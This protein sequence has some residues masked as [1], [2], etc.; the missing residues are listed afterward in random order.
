MPQSPIETTDRP[1]HDDPDG[2]WAQ[3][4]ILLGREVT[5]EPADPPRSGR[6]VVF[7]PRA[8]SLAPHPPGGRRVDQVDVVDVVDVVAPAGRGIRRHRVPA[9]YLSVAET[10]PLL[11]ELDSDHPLTPPPPGGGAGGAAGAA[12]WRRVWACWPAGGSFRQSPIR[13]MTGGEPGH[14]GRMTTV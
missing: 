7:D 9:T 3:P 12:G 10:L 5:F 6:F 13:D 8:K 1:D 4:G 11:L 14:W 2:P